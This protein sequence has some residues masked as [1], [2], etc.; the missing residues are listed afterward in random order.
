MGRKNRRKKLKQPKLDSTTKE[1]S[2]PSSASTDG[3]SDDAAPSDQKSQADPTE[4]QREPKTF[5]LP[6][7]SR[8]VSVIMLLLGILVVGLL[9]YQVMVGFFV[10]LFLAAALVV[11]FRPVHEWIY[12][13]V[14]QRPRIAAVATTSLVLM[15]VL[16]PFVLIVSIAW[17]QITTLSNRANEIGKLTNRAREQFGLTL[18]HADRF[19]RLDELTESLDD[20]EHPDKILEEIEEAKV[21]LGYLQSEVDGSPVADP[22]AVEADKQLGIFQSVVTNAKTAAEANDQLEQIRTEEEFH[23]ESLKASE[24]IHKWMS[25]KLGGPVWS[26]MKLL[27]NP[28][29]SQ[30]TNLFRTARAQLQPRFVKLTGDTSMM[31]VQILVGLLIMIIAV[32]FFLVDGPAMV[33]TLMRLS[34][35]DD[36]YE[37]QLLGEFE[38]TSRCRW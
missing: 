7:L 18:P 23:L 21:L 15:L 27:A 9:F 16:V 20:I 11:I 30:T 6:S 13:R 36:N 28:S 2:D 29:Q 32:Y 12:S 34:P 31:A 26:Q 37:R 17:S 22:T 5:E 25:E 10:P 14:G 8:V 1:L 38:R 19:R 33:R 24:L 35:L 3:P 4:E